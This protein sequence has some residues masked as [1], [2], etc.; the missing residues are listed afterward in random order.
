M[1]CSARR[2]RALPSLF[3]PTSTSAKRLS[4]GSM[5]MSSCRM[6]W[7]WMLACTR[8]SPRRFPECWHLAREGLSPRESVGYHILDSTPAALIWGQQALAS[9]ERLPIVCVSEEHE[10]R[11]A[12]GP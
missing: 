11:M 1:R 12:V 7:R 4:L 10:L 8:G 9:E 6:D 3:S 5:A 2:R